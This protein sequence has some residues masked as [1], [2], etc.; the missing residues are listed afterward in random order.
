MSTTALKWFYAVPEKKPYMLAERVRN[1]LWEMRLGGLWLDTAS[2]EPHFVL[3]GA[4]SGSNVKMEWEPNQWLRLTA[5]P[6]A[7]GLVEGLRVLLMRKPTLSFTDK[8]GHTVTEWWV[9]AEDAARRWQEIQ[10][11]P[12]FGEPKRLDQ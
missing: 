1:S 4:H 5:K 9:K 10:G 12:A 7:P 3:T 8:D 6:E 2:V 11:K